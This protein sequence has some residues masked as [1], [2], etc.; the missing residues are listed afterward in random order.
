[1]GPRR[2]KFDGVYESRTA[3]ALKIDAHTTV[4][5]GRNIFENSNVRSP[6][7]IRVGQD[8]EAVEHFLAIDREAE[9]PVAFASRVAFGPEDGLHKIQPQLIGP[10]RQGNPISERT[11]ARR[12]EEPRIEGP[13]DVGSRRN[14][15]RLPAFEVLVAAPD[16]PQAVGPRNTA[17]A[18]D[19]IT[20]QRLWQRDR[21]PA[22]G[23]LLV[24]GV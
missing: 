21:G 14:L 24:P 13:R 12:L 17:A 11:A 9:Q 15:N 4:G 23:R 3:D 1:M 2:H 20:E 8:I 16:L 19:A 5:T 18:P 7:P 10:A 22:L 6:R